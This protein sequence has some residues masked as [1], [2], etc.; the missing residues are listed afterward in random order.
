MVQS[1]EVQRYPGELSGAAFDR[2]PIRLPIKGPNPRIHIDQADVVAVLLPVG[3][4]PQAPVPFRTF[5]RPHSHPIVI[6]H[7][8]EILPLP[9]ASDAHL[10]A[11]TLIAQTVRETVLHH[12]LQEELEHKAVLHLL[13][14]PY[15]RLKSAGEPDILYLQVIAGKVD[16]VCHGNHAAFHHIVTQQLGKVIRDL[17]NLG[18]V[19]NFRKRTDGI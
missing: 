9:P 6:N 5:L 18:H 15:L 12:R 3:T 4:G 14:N 16:L 2:N 7:K 17:H 8:V 11:C 10:G 19:L 13:R 1:T